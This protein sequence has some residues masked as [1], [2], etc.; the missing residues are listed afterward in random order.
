M[1]MT[2]RWYG[3]GNDSVTVDL[4][5]KHAVLYDSYGNETQIES[6]N[7]L[8]NVSL[9]QSVKYIR[10][11]S[12]QT[13]IDQNGEE[14]SFINDDTLKIGVKF[15]VSE[16]TKN[17]KSIIAFYDSNGKLIETHVQSVDNSLGTVF[18]SV[19]EKGSSFFINVGK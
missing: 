3:E 12:M 8:Y 16:Y 17:A 13:L 6:V 2:L 1:E 19:R 9:G 4:G 10:A 5:C 15:A 11:A 7:G 18:C 14:I